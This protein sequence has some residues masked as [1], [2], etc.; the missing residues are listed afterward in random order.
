MACVSVVEISCAEPVFKPHAKILW[1]GT[2][3]IGS[4]VYYQCE[5]G[6]Q[7]KCLKKHSVCGENGQWEDIDLWCEGAMSDDRYINKLLI[8]LILTSEYL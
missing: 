8:G 4:V 1:D 7:T 5:E 2:S 6:Y 3:H